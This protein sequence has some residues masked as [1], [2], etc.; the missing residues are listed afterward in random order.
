MKRFLYIAQS[1]ALHGNVFYRIDADYIYPSDQHDFTVTSSLQERV[2]LEKT[3]INFEGGSTMKKK[4]ICGLLAAAMM[5]SLTA[6]SG[7]TTSNA[8]SNADAS[9]S[10]LPEMT[11]SIG[12]TGTEDSW[13]HAMCL[14]IK[15]KLE[16]YSGGKITVNIFPNGQM[17]SDS[18]MILSVIQGDM[19]MQ[20]T[21]TASVTNTVAD[22]GVADL[23]FLFDNVEDIRTALSDETFDSLLK[24]K[25]VE[26][27]LE[28][29][30]VADQGFRCITTNREI[31][32]PEDLAG[33]QMRVQDNPNHIE[34][35]TDATLAPTPLAFSELYLS[36]QQGLLEA[37]ENP[38]RTTVASKFYEVQKYVT[39]SNHVPQCNVIFIG[40]STFDALPAEYQEMIMRV[41]EELL[42]YSQQV[43]DES[44][45]DDL[46]FLQEQ[47]MT[48]ID[49]D[50]I[51][52]MREFLRDATLDKAIERMKES[53]DPELLDAYL[54][55][56]GYS[57]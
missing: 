32:S 25:F 34:F 49:F 7:G 36:L 50:Q 2:K 54:K 26:Q 23:P 30:V 31:K 29:L 1:S 5:L 24:E 52:G 21:N 18:E 11:F 57:S 13:N 53:I 12:H 48:F 35:W 10:E 38:Y 44:N 46:Q 16:E 19:T 9:G 45:A 28:L 39:N 56:A 47:G 33:M 8:G 4:W 6:C 14:R 42:P 17:G 37:Q 51:D 15:E 43:A 27:N 22:C 20:C 3:N 41:S 55:A 40:K